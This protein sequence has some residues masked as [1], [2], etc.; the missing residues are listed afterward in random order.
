MQFSHGVPE[1]EAVAVMSR[2]RLKARGHC[3]RALAQGQWRLL[4]PP[5]SL[6]R[7]DGRQKGLEEATPEQLWTGLLLKEAALRVLEGL[8]GGW[9]QGGSSS[10]G[11]CSAP[12]S[13]PSHAK[14]K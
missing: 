12:S 14:G 13:A 3:E 11:P 10:W 1:G 2:P 5:I 9:E 7:N 8:G 4:T 6:E